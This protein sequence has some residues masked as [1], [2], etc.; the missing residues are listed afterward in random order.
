MFLLGDGQDDD[1]GCDLRVKK[2]VDEC[3]INETFTI[4]TFGYGK[5]HDSKVMNSIANFKNGTFNFIEN[6]EKASEYF[7]LSMSGLL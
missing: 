7:V 4:N 2:L 6:I 3:G 5:D 1:S